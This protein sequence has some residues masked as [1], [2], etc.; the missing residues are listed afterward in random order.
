[1]KREFVAT[2]PGAVCDSKILLN[3]S[4]A[5]ATVLRRNPVG[6]QSSASRGSVWLLFFPNKIE[7]PPRENRYYNTVR[8]NN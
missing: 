5:V 3:P 1:M 2:T 6:K 4:H 7:Q 8:N